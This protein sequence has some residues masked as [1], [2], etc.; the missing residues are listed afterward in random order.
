VIWSTNSRAKTVSSVVRCATVPVLPDTAAVRPTIAI[1]AEAVAT[2]AIIIDRVVRMAVDS[3][4]AVFLRAAVIVA[5]VPDRAVEVAAMAM[6]MVISNHS[7]MFAINSVATIS[8][9]ENAANETIIAIAAVMAGIWRATAIC[10]RINS[11]RPFGSGERALSAARRA[12][13]RGT[14]RRKAEAVEVAEA[15]EGNAGVDVDEEMTGNVD[16]GEEVIAVAV[17][18]VAG[19]ER[20]TV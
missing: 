9:S 4:I 3:A 19:D 18:A 10:R 15:E 20:R 12:I 2:D 7:A 14:A 17:T 6:A 1:R 5:A 8:L 16:E 13:W 11:V